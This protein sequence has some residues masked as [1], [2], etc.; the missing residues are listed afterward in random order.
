MPR[1]KFDVFSMSFL[2][3]I[4]CGFGSVVLIFMLITA[5]GNAHVKK[6]TEDLRSEALL[7]E[8]QVQMAQQNLVEAKN[9]IELLDKSKVTTAGLAERVQTEIKTREEELAS[10]ENETLAARER[11][12]KLKADIQALE[13]GTR[14]LEASSKKAA[15]GG[16]NVRGFKGNGD[17]MYLTGMRVGGQRIL[18]LVDASSSMLDE[19]LV[20]ILRV[21]NMSDDRKVRTEKWRQTIAIVEWLATQ[22]PPGAQF[23]VYSFNTKPTPLL[24]G[25]EGQ[26]QKVDGPTLEKSLQQMRKL[27]P[28]GGT[29]LENAFASIKSFNP[30]PDDVILIT[31]GLPTQGDS[32]PT[33]KKLVDGDDRLKFFERAVRVLPHKL[34]VNIVLLPMEGDPAGPSA[35]WNLAKA[36]GGSIISP[37]KDWP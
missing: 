18:I 14:R 29:S 12:E 31:D 19:Q 6:K 23:Q 24:P 11:L 15:P 22:I 34:P 27:V 21:R 20:N 36:T 2:D 5:Q 30:A 16:E 10:A 37:S 3:A 1:R 28:T 25:T 8:Q 26:W 4:C 7:V 17:R 35:F 33:F 9:S 13:E 32:P